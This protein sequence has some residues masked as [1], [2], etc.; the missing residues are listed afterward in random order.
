MVS[1]KAVHAS[2]AAIGRIDLGNV[3]LPSVRSNARIGASVPRLIPPLPQL[4]RSTF[5]QISPSLNLSINLVP[6][7]NHTRIFAL[8]H[9]SIIPPK[10]NA[11]KL[12]ATTQAGSPQL[13][14]NP[15]VS[16]TSPS[17]LHPLAVA[18]LFLPPPPLALPLRTVKQT[19]TDAASGNASLVS[20]TGET[21][22]EVR[23]RHEQR[24]CHGHHS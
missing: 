3:R 12:K 11:H 15:D 14:E 19:H 18:S 22:A 1:L 5:H 24:R 6:A 16:E 10:R 17:T 23:K 8:L 4:F 9:R 20:T 2:L 7:L 13:E 21:L